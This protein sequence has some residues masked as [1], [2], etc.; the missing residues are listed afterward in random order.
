VKSP[1]PE[2]NSGRK[3]DIESRHN[4]ILKIFQINGKIIGLLKSSLLTFLLIEGF[5]PEIDILNK[6]KI[7]FFPIKQ[8]NS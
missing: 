6:Q 4:A 8:Y 7:F 2:V 1:P 5:K 3:F